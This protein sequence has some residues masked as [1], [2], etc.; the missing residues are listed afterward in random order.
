L[1]VFAAGADSFIEAQIVADHGDVFERFGSVADQRGVADGRGG[2]FS[3]ARVVLASPLGYSRN[4][5]S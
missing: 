1:A 2:R 3:L 5:F 4:I